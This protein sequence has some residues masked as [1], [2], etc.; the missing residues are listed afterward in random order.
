M[1]W[2]VH[3]GGTESRKGSVCAGMNGK[4]VWGT[5][6]VALTNY[7]PADL[8]IQASTTKQPLFT[9]SS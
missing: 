6:G 1:Q 8:V 3:K 9:C 7:P 4:A 2:M 5:Q